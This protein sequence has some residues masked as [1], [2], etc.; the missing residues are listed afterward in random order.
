MIHGIPADRAALLR[1]PTIE[2]AMKFWNRQLLGNPV[3][4]ETALAGLYKARLQW[5]G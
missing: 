2:G 4:Q 1:N 5:K 3:E